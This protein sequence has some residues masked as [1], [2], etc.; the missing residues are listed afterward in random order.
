MSV[1][2][3]TQMSSSSEMRAIPLRRVHLTDPSQLPA[4]YSSTPGGTLFSTT[5]GGTRIVYDRSM[6]MNL[7][8]SPLS[9]TP[10]QNLPSIPGVTAPKQKKAKENGHVILED[11]QAESAA[12]NPQ[13]DGEDAHQFPMEI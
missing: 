8:Q 4:S 12:S 10:P 5:P 7:R 2:P 13:H 9:Q 1:S 6:L 11:V 3:V